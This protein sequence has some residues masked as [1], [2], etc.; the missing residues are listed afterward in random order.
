MKIKP[1]SLGLKTL[2]ECFSSPRSWLVLAI[3]AASI[4]ILSVLLQSWPFVQEV[5][6]SPGTLF[7][8]MY[9]MIWLQVWYALELMGVFGFWTLWLLAILFGAN[10]ALGGYLRQKSTKETIS[11]PKKGFLG[12]IIGVLGV[13]C[14]ACNASLLGTILASI[15]GIGLISILPLKGRELLVLGFLLGFY[16]LFSL[17]KMSE[18]KTCPLRIQADKT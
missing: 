3:G 6:F 8:H 2:Y 9:G 4:F 15:G 7:Y 11:I 12:A 13:G 5:L 14:L 16:S 10:L 17:A 1:F 18:V